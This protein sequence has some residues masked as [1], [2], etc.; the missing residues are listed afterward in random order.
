MIQRLQQF[1]LTPA[2]GAI[3]AALAI[4]LSVVWGP[5]LAA[6]LPRGGNAPPIADHAPARVA[7]PVASSANKPARKAGPT[8]D[9]PLPQISLAEATRHDP[10][11]ALAWAPA[12]DRERIASSV[13]SPDEVAQRFEALKQT[14]VAML[15]VSDGGRA[16]RIGDRTLRPGDEIEGFRVV[17]IDAGGVVFEPA[18]PSA[19]DG[20]PSGG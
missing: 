13:A 18:P 12:R 4:G 20:G 3:M 10:F 15:L 7:T 17:E 6:F 2:K 5:Q 11:S 8:E 1:G 14:G 19:N 16:A 9:R